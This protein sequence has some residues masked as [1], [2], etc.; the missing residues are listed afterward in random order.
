MK[1]PIGCAIFEIVLNAQEIKTILIDYFTHLRLLCW[2]S[3]I[4]AD[5]EKK[6][7]L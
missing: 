1:S 2:N 3:N 7:G 6:D 4:N 5:S